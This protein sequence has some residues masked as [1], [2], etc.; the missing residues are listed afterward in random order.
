[1][2]G[3]FERIK[4]SASHSL[5]LYVKSDLAA[6]F[7]AALATIAPDEGIIEVPKA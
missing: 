4:S 1:M 3:F 7:E 2:S 6:D 5:A